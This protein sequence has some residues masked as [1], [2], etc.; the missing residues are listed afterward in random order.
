MKIQVR[1]IRPKC[2]RELIPYIVDKFNVRKYIGLVI[3]NC[4]EQ[5]YHCINTAYY[6][7]LK[8]SKIIITA[9]PPDWEGDYRLWEALLT[10]NLVLCDDMVLPKMLKFPLI[11]QRHLIFYKTL[12]ELEMYL[13]YYLVHDG[14]RE[15]IGKEGREYVIC[16]HTFDHCLNEILNHLR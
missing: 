9:N 1:L 13:N 3:N 10:G 12:D 4:Y 15:K 5:R 16:H 14:E 6:D 11:H 2:F 7:V 8:H